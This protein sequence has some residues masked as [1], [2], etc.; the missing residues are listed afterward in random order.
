VNLIATITFELALPQNEY[1]QF[2][3]VMPGVFAMGFLFLFLLRMV[4]VGHL[5]YFEGV[6]SVAVMLIGFAVCS[7][8]SYAADSYFIN[9]LRQKIS[10]LSGFGYMGVV[11]A[12]CLLGPILEEII[13]RGF[14]FELASL[15]YGSMI[16]WT[17]N[18]IASLGA[19]FGVIAHNFTLPNMLYVI[20]SICIF[21]TTYR[22]GRLLPC[23]AVHGFMN[24]VGF[25]APKW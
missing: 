20:G 10:I 15:K 5:K 17:V 14:I 4:G 18:L 3:Q 11:V 12:M 7:L 19:H 24:Y 9:T 13:F 25:L 22:Y 16:A 23:I 2:R 1:S 21:T 6:K 8:Y